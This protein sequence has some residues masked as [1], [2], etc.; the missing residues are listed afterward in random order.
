MK[1]RDLRNR[2]GRGAE[3]RPV[4]RDELPLEERIESLARGG[5]VTRAAEAPS[6][7]KSLV[8]RPGALARFM[9]SRD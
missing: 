1:R 2:G 3:I 5:V 7:M 6:G 4:S 9:E 8:R